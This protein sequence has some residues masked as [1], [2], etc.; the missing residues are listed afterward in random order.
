[1]K[2][3]T[4]IILEALLD[5]RT[6]EKDGDRYCL[7]EDNYFC[8]IAYSTTNGKTDTKKEVLLKVGLGDFGLR[9]FIYW[10]DKFTSEEV[11]IISA[12]KVLSNLHH[13]NR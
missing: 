12:E 5:G 13:K 11:F 2:P 6:I 3:K 7:S 8:L 1:M 10:C 4:A 9:D